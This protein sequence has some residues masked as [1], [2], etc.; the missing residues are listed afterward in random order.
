MALTVQ[1]VLYCSTTIQPTIILMNWEKLQSKHLGLPFCF[2]LLHQDTCSLL[3]LAPLHDW[4][5]LAVMNWTV[6]NQRVPNINFVLGLSF[7][8]NFSWTISGIKSWRRRKNITEIMV[9]RVCYI[10]SMT[11]ITVS[12]LSLLK[13]SLVC[14]QQIWSLYEAVIADNV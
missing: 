10:L 5:F 2:A 1:V 7:N 3:Q 14:L 13:T 12:S 6:Y 4:L 11:L 8:L 9:V